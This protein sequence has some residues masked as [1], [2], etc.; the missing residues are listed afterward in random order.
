[1]QRGAKARPSAQTELKDRKIVRWAQPVIQQLV[2]RSRR[3][4]NESKTRFL[5]LEIE[6]LFERINFGAHAIKL[7]RSDL[8][9][10]IIIISH[11]A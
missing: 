5:R 7:E 8:K 10:E 11:V 6:F 2:E 3:T 1:M 9:A 4:E